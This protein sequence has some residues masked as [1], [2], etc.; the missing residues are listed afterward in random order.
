[1][2]RM[3][4]LGL[5]VGSAFIL[6]ANG[7]RESVASTDNARGYQN[8]DDNSVERLRRNTVDPEDCILEE[9]GTGYLDETNRNYQNRDESMSDTERLRRNVVD[10]EDCT[11]DEPGTGYLDENNRK[12]QNQSNSKGRGRNRA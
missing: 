7:N 2:K 4:V 8:R 9:P 12:Y 5:L 1:M 11:L 10:P 6:S 3:I